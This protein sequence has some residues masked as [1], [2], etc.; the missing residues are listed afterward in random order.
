MIRAG[1]GAKASNVLVADDAIDALNTV[2]QLLELEGAQ[3]SVAHDGAEALEAF[4]Q[5]GFDIVFADVGMPNMD[6]YE[7]AQAVRALPNGRQGSLIALT[8]FTRPHGVQRAPKSGFDAHI[9]KPIWIACWPS[10]TKEGK[11]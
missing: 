5:G 7:F 3:V 8:G 11:S 1:A 2:R 9:G 6:G 10:G 4:R